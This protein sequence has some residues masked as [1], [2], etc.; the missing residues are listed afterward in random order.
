MINQHGIDIS[1]IRPGDKVG[2]HLYPVE[3]DAGDQGKVLFDRV[4]H[5]AKKHVVG[6]SSYTHSFEDVIFHKPKFHLFK[7]NL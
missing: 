3:I 5:M 1:K 4:I 7:K 2:I 6:A